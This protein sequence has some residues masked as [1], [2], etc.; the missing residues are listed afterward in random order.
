VKV[1][2]A[3]AAAP[4]HSLPDQHDR[5]ADLKAA[6]RFLNHPKVTPTEIQRAH[7]EPLRADCATHTRILSIQDGSELDFTHH[8]SVED[9]GFVGGGK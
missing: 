4:D 2:S 8:P 7:R 5:W 9:L 3:M 1:A 6:Y